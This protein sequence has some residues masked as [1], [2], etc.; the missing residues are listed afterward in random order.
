[1]RR[2]SVLIA[3]LAIVL[4]ATAAFAEGRNVVKFGSDIN[5]ERGMVVDEAV[6]IGGDVTVSGRVNNNVVA[7]GGSVRLGPGAFVGEEVVAVGGDVVKDPL[8][9]VKGQ[10]TQVHIPAFV[11]SLTSFAKGGWIALWATISLMA[12]LGFLGLAV[13]LTALIPVHIANAVSALQDSFAMMLVWGIVW[14]VLI[15]PI[16]VLLAISIVGIILIPLEILLV[17]LAMII[18]YIAAAIFIGKNV[19]AKFKTRSLPFVDA[20]VGILILFAISFVPIVGPI[21]KA[22][23]VTAGFGAVITTRFGTS[24]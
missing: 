7:V 16:A 18:G 3:V 20:I 14:A 21:I 23:M 22:I 4:S 13:L 17:A 1:M 8:A 12:L 10:V 19:L 15:V 2:L 11:P 5:I 24:K 6:A 9:T